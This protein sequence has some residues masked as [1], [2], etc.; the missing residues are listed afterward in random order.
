MI[1]KEHVEDVLKELFMLNV[2]QNVIGYFLVVIHVIKNVLLNVFVKKNVK[3]FV[4]MDIAMINVVKFV[5][6]VKKNAKLVVS[7]KNAKKNVGNY[8]QGSHVIKDAKKKWNVDINVMDY[9]VK[10]A[11]MF[12]KYAIQK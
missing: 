9:V 4:F 10:D 1:V 8:V 2:N 3:I 7:M 5:L 11:Q 12:A 6:I